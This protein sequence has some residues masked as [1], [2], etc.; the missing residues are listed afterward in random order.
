MI[1]LATACSGGDS[2]TSPSDINTVSIGTGPVSI[3]VVSGDNQSGLEGMQAP[4]PV[5]VR[6]VDRNGNPVG[7]VPVTFTP[8][9]GSGTVGVASVQSDATSGT[10]TL[11]GW[12]F[13]NATSQSLVVTSPSLPGKSVTVRAQVTVSQF[14]IDVRFVG[15][16]GT[17]RQREA[18]AKAVIRWRRVIIGDIGSTTLNAPAGECA[19]WL[20]AIKETLNDL[21]IYVRL[22]NIDGA[23]KTLGQAS[24]CY[25]NSVSKLPVLGF[26]ELDIDDLALLNNN[27]TL[28]DVVLHEMG[29]ILGI[30][31]LWSHQRTLLSGRGGDDP[32][33][34]GA[35]ARSRFATIPGNSYSGF[36]VP[37]ENNGGVGTRDSH[38]R[39]SVFAN[40]LMQGYAQGGGMPLSGVTIGSL[41][42]LGYTVSYASASSY[43]FLVAALS[44]GAPNSAAVPFGDDI[45]DS[46]LWEVS[47]SGSRRLVREGAH[48]QY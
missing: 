26:F 30:G 37:V 32:Y 1:V 15:D 45:A 22:T 34:T 13:G 25:V 17:D 46:P 11:S 6:V 27:G 2:P 9:A 38:W 35:A 43:S 18:F 47:P 14:D 8:G 5:V 19:S 42:D 24:P 21:V 29:H 3:V 10:A 40:E 44:D 28:D 41:A 48:D 23:G 31:T 39:R 20:P 36:P 4:A 7:S 33:F 12:T 16:G